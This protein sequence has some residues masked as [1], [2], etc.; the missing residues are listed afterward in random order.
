MQS[1]QEIIDIVNSE[2][3]GYHTGNRMILPFKCNFIKIIADSQIVTEFKKNND[4]TVS[5]EPKNTS[6]YFREV[7]RLKEFEGGYQYIKIIL[8]S[9]EDDLSNPD[10]H[11]KMICEIEENHKVN[12]KIPGDDVLFIA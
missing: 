3:R 9:L 5:Q 2:V 12:M 6:L 7:G 10:N 8:A 1:R 4:L 11:I